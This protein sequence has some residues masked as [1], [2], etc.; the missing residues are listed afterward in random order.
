MLF[1]MEMATRRVHI[2]GVTAH[3]DPTWTAQ[4]ARNLAMDLAG[5]M[6]S[7]R[8]PHRDRDAKFTAAFDDVFASEAEGNFFRRAAFRFWRP[9]AA[10]P[11]DGRERLDLE[12]RVVTL[13]D[14]WRFGT[15]DVAAS[16]K[17]SADYTVV[18]MW[19]VAPDGDLILLDRR[20]RQ[21]GA[22]RPLQ[23][24]PAVVPAVGGMHAVG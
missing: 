17:T 5:R 6:G 16:T 2:P 12:G 14:C 9:M 4:Q 19:A 24:G 15:V 11:G 13:A 21:V 18:S 23:P 3:P 7:F 1:V 22:A 10:W 20:R 8:F